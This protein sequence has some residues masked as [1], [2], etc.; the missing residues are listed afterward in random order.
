MPRLFVTVAFVASGEPGA[1]GLVETFYA[2]PVK[3]SS[4]IKKDEQSN[5]SDEDHPKI[6]IIP[7]LSG[8]PLPGRRIEHVGNPQDRNGN[9]S[10]ADVNDISFLRQNHSGQSHAR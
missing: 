3:E 2:A 9:E 8:A 1:V 6:G 7:G 4:R 5:T 10:A